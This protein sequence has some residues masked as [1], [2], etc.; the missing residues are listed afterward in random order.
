MEHRVRSAEDHSQVVA[1][2]HGTSFPYTVRIVKGDKRTGNQ[3]N[4]AFDWYAQAARH[5]GDRTATDVRAYCKLHHGV[6]IRREIDEDFREKYDRIIRPHSYEDKLEMMVDP[7][8]FPVTRDF[9]VPEMTRY[10][11]AVYADLSGQG[12]RLT[13][14]EDRR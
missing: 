6:P 1:E 11:D 9:K 5:Y 12:I 13:L 10:M 14:P 3:N 7:I 8:D 2:M 4:L